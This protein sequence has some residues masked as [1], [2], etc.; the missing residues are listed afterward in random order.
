M[1]LTRLMRIVVLV[2][3]LS[4]LAGASGASAAGAPAGAAVGGVGVAATPNA[5]FYCHSNTS[6]YIYGG[7]YNAYFS[8]NYLTT[9][10]AYLPNTSLC[11]YNTTPY[12]QTVTSNCLSGAYAI[13]P[14]TGVLGIAL[15]PGRGYCYFYLARSS[16]V[17]T[18][19]EQG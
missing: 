8:P 5:S 3:L 19:F 4:I 1:R 15:A 2:S 14:Y 7:Y 12:Y 17:L 9:H 10:Y 16:S 6:S 13:A 11:I 18:V